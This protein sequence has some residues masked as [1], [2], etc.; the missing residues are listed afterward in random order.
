M[1][2]QLNGLGWKPFFQT[3]LSLEEMEHSFPARVAEVQRSHVV[4]WSERTDFTMD[5]ALAAQH[6]ALAVGDW[7]LMFDDGA[8]PNRTLER[9]SLISR[10][11]PG[12]RAEI[13]LIAS[14]IDTLFIVS[15]C[16]EDFNESRIERYLVLAKQAKVTP[17]VVLTKADLV[18]DVDDFLH[19]AEKLYPGVQVECLDTRN[20]EQLNAIRLWCATGQTVALVGSSGVGKTTMI[21]QLT[22]NRLKTAAIREDDAK[23]RHTTTSRS[24]H[25][26]ED[27]GLLI[28]TP[29][30]REIQLALAESGIDEVFDDIRDLAQSCKFSDCK[31]DNEPGCAV[32]RAL[33]TG[34]VDERRWKNYKKLVSENARHQQNLAEKRS[35]DRATGKLYKSIQKEKRQRDEWE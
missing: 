13:Q 5:I 20:L 16:N 34:D 10:K 31:H 18:D 19:A 14:N 27:G 26:L 29:G 7:L 25:R 23:G 9:Y 2:H 22:G 24:M 12:D 6:Q 30:M 15:S 33:K 28:D 1:H 17:L 21:N 11:A 3:Q 35:R 8:R 4:L 32:V